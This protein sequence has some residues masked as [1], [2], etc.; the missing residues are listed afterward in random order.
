[1]RKPLMGENG[2]AS[3]RISSY[4]WMAL[5]AS[6]SAR[7]ACRSSSHAAAAQARGARVA[8]RKL[9]AQLVLQFVPHVFSGLPIGSRIA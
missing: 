3:S 9:A 8:E 4:N 2:R 5:S 6:A 1:M 7:S